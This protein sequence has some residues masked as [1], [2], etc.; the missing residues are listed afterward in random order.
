M[1]VRFENCFFYVAGVIRSLLH[2]RTSGSALLAEPARQLAF[3][4][5][6]T[7]YTEFASAGLYAKAA[8]NATL[9]I[10]NS[11]SS[12][13]MDRF[14]CKSGWLHN[15]DT[16]AALAVGVLHNETAFAPRHICAPVY[17]KR[18]KSLTQGNDRG[19]DVA[20]QTYGFNVDTVVST[21]G[22]LV[23][24][25]LADTNTVYLMHFGGDVGDVYVSG[26]TGAVFV[27][28]SRTG[29]Q[30]TMEAMSGFDKDGNLLNSIVP[31]G[32]LYPLNCR[33]YALTA[34]LY[35]DITA[36]SPTVTNLTLGNGSAPGDLSS[37]LT[38]D[39]YLYVDQEVDQVINPF[40]GDAR[41]VSFNTGARTMTFQGNFN[42]SQTRRR[43]TI[44]V[45]PAFPN[46]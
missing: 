30:F 4:G 36:A 13:C 45:R 27:V 1:Q 9:G 3:E 15:L 7:N 41:L 18:L 23:T 19:V 10:T 31:G 40:N 12:T 14:S 42:Y 34:V 35:G 29:M 21:V 17:A 5:C 46:T 6:M 33:R 22:R 26:A 32:L 25:T 24:F 2:F 43:F 11:L 38:A 39:D 8:H 16:G 28:K 44:F 20:W 37:I